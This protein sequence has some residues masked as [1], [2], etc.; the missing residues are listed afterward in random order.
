MSY[1]MDFE[2]NIDAETMEEQKTLLEEHR[3]RHE[4]EMIEMDEAANAAEGMDN[5]D[6]NMLR[7]D[8]KEDRDA[9]PPQAMDMPEDAQI[10]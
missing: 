8:V 3:E 10:H 9:T 7:E 2:T 6:D 4:N 1:R 5:R